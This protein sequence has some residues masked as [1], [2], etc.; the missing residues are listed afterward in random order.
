MN[1]I[2]KKSSLFLTVLF[3][4][5]M[6]SFNVQASTEIRINK[7]KVNL[8][9]GQSVVLFLSANDEKI[10]SGVKWFSSN[11]KIVSVSRK[12]KIKGKKAG[13]TT[14]YAKYKGKKYKC[15]VKVRNS[16]N[17]SKNTVVLGADDS[18]KSVT[19]T[20]RE[21]GTIIYDIVRGD[22]LIDCEWAENWTGNKIKLKI[23]R[24][25]ALS[26]GTAKIKIYSRKYKKNYKI[27]T[28]KLISPCK[29]SLLNY[30]PD[31]FVNYGNSS[32]YPDGIQNA[33]TVNKVQYSIE[34]DD[35]TIYVDYTAKY[36][37]KPGSDYYYIYYKIRDPKG[38][39][40]ESSFIMSDKLSVGDRAESEIDLLDIGRGEY[41]IEFLDHESDY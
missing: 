7:S 6:L 20:F 9:Y 18:K 24:L 34:D 22:N 27:L 14:V 29:L 1:R 30:L 38:Y 21:K 19:V 35:M 36:S 8:S 2:L 32:L 26:F 31:T 33:V 5:S 23:Y 12:G 16:V 15:T 40:V 25:D 10:Y 3:V 28:V 37:P 11:K 13:K 4:V 39:V 41:T 17:L